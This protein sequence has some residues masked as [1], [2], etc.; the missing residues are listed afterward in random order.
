MILVVTYAHG[1]HKLLTKEYTEEKPV[2]IKNYYDEQY[3]APA[4]VVKRDDDLDVVILVA[5]S[6]NFLEV[7]PPITAAEIG[8]RY[9]MVVY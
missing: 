2:V 5:I 8:M 6:T 1:S 7:K 9:L 3:S 4:K